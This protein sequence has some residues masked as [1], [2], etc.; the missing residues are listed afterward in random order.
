[1]YRQ[2]TRDDQF[3]TPWELLGS[4]YALEWLWAYWLRAYDGHWS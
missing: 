3:W 1:M 4:H 2:I